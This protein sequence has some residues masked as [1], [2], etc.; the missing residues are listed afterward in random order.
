MQQRLCA[1]AQCALGWTSVGTLVMAFRGTESLK[2]VLADINL[3]S[4][5]VT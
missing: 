3:F 2:H 1:C 5:Q 4:H